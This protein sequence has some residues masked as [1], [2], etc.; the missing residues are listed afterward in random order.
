MVM[1]LELL[2]MFSPFAVVL[3]GL[4]SERY[5][6]PNLRE[7]VAII[8]SVFSLFSVYQLYALWQDSPSKVLVITL[9]GAP[10]LGACFEIDMLGIYMAFSA[11]LLGLFAVIYSVNYM[12]HDTR[13][14]E[15]YTLLSALVVSIVGVSFAG[16]FFTLFIFW[17]LMGITSYVLVAFRKE[18][19]GPIEAGF[20]YMVMGAVGSTLLLMGIALIYGMAGTVNFA[21]ISTALRGQPMSLWLYLVFAILVV[22]FG[23]KSAIVPMH[24]WLPDAHP[25]APSPISAMLS[26]ILIET[27]LYGFIRVL[28]LIYEPGTFTLPIAVLAVV[29]MCLANVLALLQQDLKRMLAYSSIAQ[30]GYM[31]VGLSAGTAFG[32]QGVLLHVFNHSLMKGLAFFSA[33]S[34]IHNT[35]SREI[36]NM[37]GLAK[38]MPITSLTMFIAMMGLGGVPGTNGFIS[39]FILFSSAFGVGLWWLGLLGVLN[40]ALSMAYYLRFLK[41]LI[42]RPAEAVSGLKEAPSLMLGVTVSMA[43]LVILFGIWPEPL[44]S[45]ASEAARALFNNNYI[46][47]IMP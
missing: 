1:G 4:L 18:N 29:T 40:S 46:K 31:L 19:W 9:G 34:L 30:V 2:F 10:P 3:F 28:Y 27:A 35:N 17:E 41:T 7:V 20:K 6:V 37:K 33:G 26:G 8:L 36:D 44:I 45:Y 13:V 47:V 15:Y 16:D 32:I 21:Q 24:T 11:T 22:G 38:T 39:K 25:E 23:I 42:S 12:A 14:T 43:T 5:K